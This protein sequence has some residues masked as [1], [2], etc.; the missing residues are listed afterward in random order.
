MWNNNKVKLI[1]FTFKDSE[2]G[3]KMNDYISFNAKDIFEQLFERN[4]IQIILIS[5]NKY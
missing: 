2:C 1:E 5:T 3:F 4:I